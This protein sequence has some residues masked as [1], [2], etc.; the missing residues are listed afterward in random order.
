MKT[1]LIVLLVAFLCYIITGIVLFRANFKR[2]E[3]EVKEKL[4]EAAI[5]FENDLNEYQ[6]K[7]SD[8]AQE[9]TFAFIAVTWIFTI[10]LLV[11]IFG[12]IVT[13][14]NKLDNSIFGIEDEI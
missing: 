12:P 9:K 10:A 5:H 2:Y 13:V 4:H 14:V 7:L 6:I 3:K 11:I 8:K 1:L